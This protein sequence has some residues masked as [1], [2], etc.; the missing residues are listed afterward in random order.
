[1]RFKHLVITIALVVMSC[2]AIAG[3]TTS[4]QSAKSKEPSAAASPSALSSLPAA[5]EFKAEDLLKI[6]DVQYRHAQRAAQ[7]K[8]LEQQYEQLQKAQEADRQKVDQIINDA[9][10]AANVDLTKWSL[11]I[12]ELK[13]V[14]RDNK[15]A[16][17]TNAAPPKGGTPNAGTKN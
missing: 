16:P 1:M 2:A 15:Q 17:A 9:A 13:F 6:R 7:M 10:R 11:D 14:S 5:P 4:A 12:E 8:I 3:Q